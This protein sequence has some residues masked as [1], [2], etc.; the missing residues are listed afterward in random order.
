MRQRRWTT[1]LLLAAGL[2]MPG[3]GAGGPARAGGDPPGLGQV[4]ALS[5]DAFALAGSRERRLGCDETLEVGETLTTAKGA[6]VALLAGAVYAELAGD[7]SLELRRAAQ[8]GLELH[9]RRGR[10]RAVDTRGE[11]ERTPFL[12]TTPHLV[13]EA[14]GTDSEAW[15]KGASSGMCEH[16]GELPVARAGDGESLTARAGECAVGR[17][18]AGLRYEKAE[19]PSVHVS[20]APVCGRDDRIGPVASRFA[21]ADVASPLL[22]ADF[23][24]LLQPGGPSRLPCDI[25]LD[26]AAATSFG[27]PP[28]LGGGGFPGSESPSFGEAPGLGG[29]PFPG[30]EDSFGEPSGLGGGSFPGPS[31]E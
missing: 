8:G 19:A 23:P 25:G 2:A 18:G 6:R 9:L 10:V 28:G 3:L 16:A 20:S 17:S 4:V 26:C 31:I 30:T 15:V 24:P 5:G 21:P 29:G 13:G 11:G 27:E 14:I 7:S 12:L 1:R 22:A